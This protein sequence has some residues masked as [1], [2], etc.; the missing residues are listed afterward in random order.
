MDSGTNQNPPIFNGI[1]SEVKS[2]NTPTLDL[3]DS[4]FL[5]RR[6]CFRNPLL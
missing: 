5:Q 6:L 1:E 4:D 2:R 3:I